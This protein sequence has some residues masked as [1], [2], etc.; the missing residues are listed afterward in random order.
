MSSCKSQRN[1][2]GKKN[3]KRR[4]VKCCLGDL[5]AH[6]NFAGAEAMT[7]CITKRGSA[8][9]TFTGPQCHYTRL[10]SNSSRHVLCARGCMVRTTKAGSVTSNHW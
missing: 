3:G 1:Q 8:L 4:A 10:A 6:L 2:L 9:S 7:L 5:R